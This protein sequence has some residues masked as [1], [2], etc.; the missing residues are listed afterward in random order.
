[1]RYQIKANVKYWLF[2][3]LSVFSL[4]VSAF[5]INYKV[6]SGSNVADISHTDNSITYLIDAG[7]ATSYT[8]SAMTV[9]SGI[10]VAADAF[11][12]QAP[13]ASAGGYIFYTFDSNNNFSFDSI[14]IYPNL[15]VSAS[16]YQINLKGYDG[17]TAATPVTATITVPLGQIGDVFTITRDTDFS[18][19]DWQNVDT[20]VLEFYDTASNVYN[21]NFAIDTITVTPVASNSAPTDISLSAT[22][23]NQS[24]TGA[25]ATVGTLSS[26]DAD[27]GDSHTY[28]LV[29]NG[30]S[31]NGTCTASGDD[32]NAS[33]SISSTTF[34]TQ[35]ALSAGSYNVCV[36]TDDGTTTFQK[37]FSITVNDNVAP[38]APS[39]PDLDA[40]SDTGSSNTDN[41]TK[42]TT[43]TLSGTAESGSTVTLYSDQVNGGATSI[44]SG[45][46]SGG[47]WQITTSALSA[48][49]HA[50]SA[51]ATDGSSNVSS[52]SSSLSVTIDTNAPTVAE[53]AVVTT[54]TNDTTP[55]YTFSTTETGTLVM[56]GS[57][58]TSTSTTIGS[59]GNQTITLTQT[60]NSTAL[61]PGT[62]TNCTVTV[63][64]T[65]GNASVAQAVTSFT[66]DTTTPTF[67]SAN[68]TPNDNATNVTASDNIV[69]DFSENIAFGSG[70]ITIRNVSNS[71]DF[72]V[73]NVATES[74]GTTTTPGA[75]RVGITNDKIYLNPTNNLIG[76]RSYAIRVDA[77]AVDDS[78]GNS[79][80]G[81]SNDTTFNFTTANTAPDV[82]LNSGTGGNDN[83]APFSEGSGAVN[84]AP[85]AA[86]TEADGDT[87]TAI[88]VS[89]SNNQDGASEGLSVSA[90]AQNALTGVSGASDIT[91]QDTIS[92]TGAAA[93]AAEVTTFLQAITYNNTSNS[94]NTT[95]RTVTVVINDGTVNSV[96][97]TATISVSNVTATSSSAA[98]FNTTNG[99]NL[100]PAITFTSDNETLTIVNSNHVTGST[101]DGGGGTDTLS[102]VTGTDLTTLTSLTN[103]ET[104]TPDNDGALT[105][106]ETQHEGFTT[107]NGTGTNQF[108]IASADGDQ[109]LT[110][111]ADI[112]TY[113]LGAAMTFNAATAAQNVTGSSGD[114]TVNVA[115]L[116]ATGTLSGG[117]GTDT[118]QLSNGANIS[119]ATVA[120]FE[121]L[122]LAND[123][124]VTM[125]EAQHDGFSTMTAFG[126]ETITI[127]TA[128]DGLTGN[129]AIETYVL[130]AA[131]TFTLGS[132]GQNLTGSGGDDTV[133]VGALSAT[134]TLAGGAGADTLS[135]ANGGSIAGA[136]V[137]GFENLAVASGG[138]ASIDAAQLS[139]FS[140][141][142]SG[143]GSE[144]LTIAGDGDITTVSAIESY[145]LADDSTNTRTV[146]VSNSSHSVTGTSTS[147]AVTFDLG[148]LTYTG[149]ITGDSTTPD[150]LSLSSGADITGA[151]IN[152]V[153]NLTL[154]S[155][156][157]VAMTLAQHAN[158]TGTLTAAGV[159]TISLS[160]NGNVTTLVGIENYNLGDDSSNTRTITMVSDATSVTANSATDAVTFAI[161]GSSFTG[162][163]SGENTVPD[164]VQ[165]SDGADITG[166]SFFNIGSLSLTSGATVAIDSA[167]IGDF[168]S[169]IT[170][171]GGSETLKL[172]DGGTFNFSTT[173]VSAID[174]IAIGTNS[175]STITLTDNFNA[176]G[177]TVAITNTTG[178]AIT[179][180]LSI[181][182][183]AFVGDVLSITATDLG[184]DDTFVG[185][186]GADIIRPGAGTDTMTGN[187]GGDNFIGSASDLS[188][189]TIADLAIGDQITI[190]GVTG[191]SSANVRFNG[192]STLEVDTDATDFNISELSLSLTNA[193]AASLVYTVADSGSDTVITFIAPNEAP[194]FSSLNGGAT[195]VE[196]G[197]AV[198]IDNDMTVADTELDALNGGNGSYDGATVTIARSGGA[199][200]QDEFSHTGLLGS[201]V[202][203][204][205]FTYNASSVGTVTTNSG[206]SLVLSFN[207]SATSAIVDGV[208]Q[209][210]GYRNS[211]EDPASSV[212][213]NFTFNDGTIDSSGSNQAVVNITAQNDTPTDIALSATSINQSATGAGA[214]V[215]TATSTDIDSSDSHSYSLVNANASDSGSCSASSGNSRFQFAANTLQTK[216]STQPGSYTIC[217]QTSD[218]SATFQE[219]F[220]ITV[221]DNVAPNAPSTPDLDSASDSGPSNSDNITNDTTPTLSGSAESGATVK[222]YSSQVGS[223]N[224]V[225][226]STVATGGNWQITTAAL[227]SGLTHAITAEATD[228]VNNVSG[229]SSALNLT[230]DTQYPNASSAPDMTSS[231]DSGSSNT[232]NITSDTTPTFTGQGTNGD[233]ITLISDVDGMLGSTIVTG[234]VWSITAN[235]A[236]TAG[237]HLVLARAAD[238]A[239]NMTDS[240]SLSINIDAV[241]PSGV[242]VSIEQ[243]SINADNETALSFSLSGLE[244]AGS[245]SFTYQISDGTNKVNS[246]SAVAVSGTTQRVSGV[247]VSN[248][249]EGTLTLTVLV[250]DIAGNISSAF[251]DTVTKRYNV[252]PSAVNDTLTTNEDSANQIN[253]LSND[254]DP[255]SN[256]VA[257][258]VTI[259]SAPAKGQVSVSNGIITYTPNANANGADS[260]TYT[261]KDAEQAESNAATVSVTITA[262][263]DLPV[264]ANFTPSIEEDT[265]TEALTV[266]ASATD[267]EDT[268]P[269]GTITLETLPMKGNAAVDQIN[270]T[271]T[272]T[273]NANETGSDSF[274]Y[275]IMDSEGAKSNIA[276][277]TVNIGAV[278]DEPIALDDTFIF[279]AV[280]ANEYLLPVLDNDVDP[281]GG[282]LKITGAKASIG[283]VLIENNKLT[284]KTLGNTQGPI[285]VSYIIENGSQAR[286]QANANITINGKSGGNEPTIVTPADLT[287]NATGLFTKVNLGTAVATD[288]LGN[289]I[290]VSLASGAP[291]FTPGNH[292]VYWQAID[293]Q[294][295]QAIAS[296]EVKVN[297]L[298]SMQKDSQV[299]EGMSTT[300]K[301]YLNGPAPSYPVTLAYTVQGSADSGDHDLTDGEIIITQGLVGE[302]TFNVFDDASAEGTETI[303]IQLANAVNLGARSATTLSIVE[304]NVAP[305]LQVEVTQGG[306]AR[307]L[308]LA[309]EQLVTLNTTVT[310]I[311]VADRVTVSFSASEPLIV[312]ESNQAGVMT[313]SPAQLS[314]GVYKIGVTATDDG[315]P[316]LSSRNDVYVEV[317][318]SLVALTEQDTDGDLIPDEKEGYSD[319]DRDGIP[320]YLDSIDECNVLQEQVNNANQFLVET[321]ASGCLRKGATV[322]QNQT[323]G[324]QLLT[325][326]TPFDEAA[327][328][329]GGIFDFIITEIPQAGDAMRVVLP[330][331]LPIPANAVYRKY[332]SG[333]WRDFVSTAEDRVFS[334]PGEAGYCPPPGD[335]A[336]TE[337]LTE[338]HWC[339][340]LQIVDGGPNDDDGV[341]NSTIVDPGGVAIMKTSNNLPMAQA[342][343]VNV[344]VGDSIT[345]DVLANDSDADGDALV[346]TSASVD[347]GA[348]SIVGNQLLYVPTTN[349]V[350]RA[351]IQYGI[352]DQQ[353]G[354]ASNTVTVDVVVNN[355]PLAN[356]DSATTTDQVSIVINV[357]SNDSDA[358]GDVLSVVSASAV[359]GQVSVGEDGLLTYSPKLGFEGVDNIIYII[360]DELGARA[361]GE[362]Q[363]I[364]TANKAVTIENTSSGGGSIGLVMLGLIFAALVMRRNKVALP[365]CLAISA[366]LVMTPSADASDW[367]MDV[368][369]G[370]ASASGI[371]P[372]PVDAS[373]QKVKVDKDHLSWS[374]GLYYN[375]TPQWQVGLKYIDLGKASS[376]YQGTALSPEQ[377]HQKFAQSVVILPQGG[378]L[379]LGY[380]LPKWGKVQS[381][382]FAGALDYRYK[383]KSTLNGGN[384]L[385]H[386]SHQTAAYGGAELSY[387]MTEQ[388]SLAI[389]YSFYSLKEN[390]VNDFAIGI[391]Y[392]F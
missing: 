241:A 324:A 284:L 197:A 125:T 242:S 90:A 271:I 211:S 196:N 320:D 161:G 330:Q 56:G 204:N 202:Q 382:V 380:K 252:A 44:G 119:G 366:S 370:Y 335:A 265:A 307:Q 317:V 52:S 127:S 7:T 361:Q 164:Q 376:T 351:S 364:V 381:K 325:S 194:V 33:F 355:P 91:L 134:G 356:A 323:G 12:N 147:D 371:A 57:C 174:A 138:A 290:P 24:A 13:S 38:N 392:L 68:S 163:L 269:T 327:Q 80:A 298:I 104:L 155:G 199:N 340:Q 210:I 319:T 160:G 345:I 107:I 88:T 67:D 308:V 311:N 86:V 270:G 369:L 293:N 146:T 264:A 206:G 168:T 2:V 184:G 55:N 126:T 346:I 304:E 29:T 72:E 248:L 297:P 179:N 26:T 384:R 228:S 144:T 221:V 286:A 186:S 309:N 75:G 359:Q 301:V 188:G 385:R 63:T 176:D 152:N 185:G 263:N 389:N 300:V 65:A 175:A 6:K 233:T 47:N 10:A 318:S 215:A 128:T 173:S 42:D 365:Y 182:A 40:A 141:T 99:T 310:D 18:G 30:A 214:A 83:S 74:D 50:I 379:Q 339:V 292:L 93:T 136:T 239:G 101:A 111:D 143:A 16:N 115:A 41:I 5:S 148:A 267:I 278:N 110:G 283:T 78:A 189:D 246:T 66:I 268:H 31:A 178:S 64:D 375:V 198:S 358:E 262:I 120:A 60:N 295:R 193:P 333:Q 291:V 97:R 282:A 92:I 322:A 352:S 374:A 54:P 222:L 62:Y 130:G 51:K 349:F 274:N 243:A 260:F 177:Q 116:S 22:S 117:T 15:Q 205:T 81:I 207:S 326:E 315:T 350:G 156:A 219:S 377:T 82:D 342:D 332:L 113:V 34:Q 71:S 25:S 151:T 9:Y 4:S 200:S 19:A 338:G 212:T 368:T 253:V 386:K 251:S 123:A 170:G 277:I 131:N 244:G 159:E 236:M 171:A 180:D 124:S 218:G 257:S 183:S 231:T 39:T 79:F 331:R 372:S 162:T 240:A 316:S 285:I 140:G 157:S 181:N 383:I 85:S 187:A 94:P 191:L 223:G 238:T 334:S 153:A 224:T 360:Q 158:F 341:V 373:V 256:I 353:G 227:T 129:S 357:L 43:L 46:A 387:P 362:V 3:W 114:D 302:V 235:T 73:F 305:T 70:N 249:A 217:I 336:W 118:L 145:T 108:T 112:E 166:G 250:K 132:A 69:I 28:S 314:P 103:F 59:T 344:A 21:N 280:V 133:N 172:M 247:N 225:I 234:S 390:D 190:T 98:A 328:N 154:A 142:I 321:E 279:D 201:L 261:V 23:I 61:A 203:G 102:V 139:A 14:T 226:G 343:A 299:V 89:L 84:V 254:T 109:T 232:D 237:S 169:A 391:K 77:T 76:N 165:V 36:Q 149:T 347:F 273:P 20:V 105:L 150:T 195:F 167:N 45:T 303:Q 220:T 216:V 348:V 245:G 281:D 11:I 329:M 35:S 354:T 135:I 288:S 289:P 1:M 208:L 87:I 367:S 337:G 312:D 27:G 96:S 255:E 37:T 32:D 272:Y 259:K 137:S 58:G 192:S 294:G 49:T 121:A 230:I 106:S 276:T 48:G 378:A 100:S 363:V 313:F 8:S 258:S 53:V 209:S 287:V 213:L 296:Q 17:G 266:R 229:R 388:W 95:A 306:Q 275:S 122:T